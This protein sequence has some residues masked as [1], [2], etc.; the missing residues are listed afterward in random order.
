MATLV[1]K[2]NLVN[3]LGE[4]MTVS[5]E[6]DNTQLFKAAQVWVGGVSQLYSSLL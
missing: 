6:D 5:D 2:M 4:V 1:T 3:G